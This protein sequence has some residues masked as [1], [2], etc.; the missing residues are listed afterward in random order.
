MKKKKIRILSLCL[1]LLLVAGGTTG[2]LIYYKKNKKYKH[3]AF[4]HCKKR[5]NPYH[6]TNKQYKRKR[7]YLRNRNR[8][9]GFCQYQ[10]EQ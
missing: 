2:G 3:N 10:R 9:G 7:N 4:H 1:A 5:T 6:S 8:N